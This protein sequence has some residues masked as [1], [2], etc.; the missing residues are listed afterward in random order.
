MAHQQQFSA[1][2]AVGAYRNAFLLFASKDKTGFRID[3]GVPM[4]RDTLAGYI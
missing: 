1:H 3:L 2:M 4:D